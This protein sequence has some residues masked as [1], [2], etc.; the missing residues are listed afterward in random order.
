M[1]WFLTENWK[2]TRQKINLMFCFKLDKTLKQTHMV[3]VHVYE[4]EELSMKC[5]Y[6]WFALFQEA[7]ESVSENPPQW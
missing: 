6:D 3:L 7:R 4:D 5:V 1:R 2:M